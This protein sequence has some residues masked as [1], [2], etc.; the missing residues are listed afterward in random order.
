MSEP[1]IP[2]GLTVQE[3]F[4]RY[5]GEQ[6]AA[7]AE[8]L[9]HPETDGDAGPH[10][11]VPVQPADPKL[12]WTDAA[13][14]LGITAEAPAEWSAL[15]TQATPA[16]SLAFAL[17]NY[18]QQVRHVAALLMSDPAGLREDASPGAERP[19]LTTWAAK[20]SGAGR[21]LAAGVLRQAR[22]FAE[23]AK[24]LDGPL[25]AELEAVR[26]NERAALLW[27]RGERTAALAAWK[28]L[29]DSTPVLFNRGMA[30]LFTGH[31]AEAAVALAEAQAKLPETSAWHHLAGLYLAMASGMA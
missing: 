24:L 26:G 27:H 17:G 16:V 29:P 6:T 9:G 10:D 3:L 31:A 21:L 13:A 25:P 19:A 11:T 14:A 1:T 23:A 20:Q 4:G 5:L 15:V 8:G 22:L 30:L 18:P 7:H 12:A 28:A 2:A